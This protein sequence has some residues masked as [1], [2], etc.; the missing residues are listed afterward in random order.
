MIGTATSDKTE[1]IGEQIERAATRISN[2]N[3]V[4]LNI[5]FWYSEPTK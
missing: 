2:E 1:D 5:M 4:A 3:V